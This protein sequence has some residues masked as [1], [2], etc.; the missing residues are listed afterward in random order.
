MGHYDFVYEDQTTEKIEK[1]LAGLM[2]RKGVAESKLH[3]L[4]TD[5]KNVKTPYVKNLLTQDVSVVERSIATLKKNI[6]D[7]K[8]LLKKKEDGQQVTWEDLHGGRS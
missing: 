7:T 5:L 2:F 1:Q 4:T 8:V 6:K 3:D